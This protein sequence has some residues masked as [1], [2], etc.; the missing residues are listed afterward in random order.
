M[1]KPSWY[2]IAEGEIGV[3]ENPSNITDNP[4][5]V[6]YFTATDFMNRG[7]DEIPW[8]SA[9]ANW[10]MTQAGIPGTHSARAR[11][12]H[13]AGWGEKLDEP[14]EGCL[15]V[16]K[17]P[18]RPE[19]GH[20]G[21]YAGMADDNRIRLLGG[22]Q[23][24][25]GRGAVNISNQSK[26]LVL[27]YRWPSPEMLAAAGQPDAEKPAKVEVKIR[28]SEFTAELAREYE[29][30]FAACKL[31][32]E[33]PGEVDAIA[34]KVAGN[35]PLYEKVGNPLRIPWFVV[36]VIHSMECSC[37]FNSHM[38]NGDPLN[39]YTVH[40]PAGRPDKG[41]PPFSW[42]VSAMDAL[43]YKQFNV[44]TDWSLAGILYKLELYNGWG[45]R[46]RGVATPYLW[47]RSNLYAKG[48][49][50]R[51]G[52]FDPSAVSK[53]V[54]AAVILKRMLEKGVLTLAD[55]GLKPN[56]EGFSPLPSPSPGKFQYDSDRKSQWG[57]DLQ[58]FLNL[59]EWINLDEDGYPGDETSAAFRQMTGYFLPGDERQGYPLISYAPDSKP[60]EVVEEFQKLLNIYAPKQVKVTGVAGEE[61]S[62]A[63]KE[64]T[65][66]YL[67]GDPRQKG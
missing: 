1:S 26:D 65:G 23:G 10:C 45:Y 67:Y 15:V 57:E 8:C 61:T 12:W 59:V 2:E 17:R 47:S 66:Y 51:D 64:L 22:N 54:G 9:F 29:L 6:E 55:L 11:S 32:A 36:G 37:D 30:L 38:H 14:R 4:R 53:Q 13:E 33:K 5:V 49:F 46:K 16:F 43:T 31:D 18:P 3:T 7:D 40:V 58:G 34:N 27:S 19:N 24:P 44:W 28:R 39:N 20:V 21:F 42:E 56:Q 52:V 41:S 62:D 35:K 50:V 63:F 25:E 48:K 60:W